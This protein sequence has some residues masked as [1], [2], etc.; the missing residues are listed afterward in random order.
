MGMGKEKECFEEVLRVRDCA[1]PNPVMAK[2][3]DIL[4]DRKGELAKYAVAYRKMIEGSF[5]A[6]DE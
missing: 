2:L 4:L 6:K 1:I 3:A 5:K